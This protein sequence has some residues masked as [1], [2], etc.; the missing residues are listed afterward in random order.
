MRL[1]DI[2]NQKF[3]KLTAIER[4]V[5]NNTTY[6]KCLCDCG[7]WTT[8]RMS[9][10]TRT[11]RAGTKSCGCFSSPD[12]VGKKFGR[13]TVLNQTEKPNKKLTGSSFWWSCKCDCGKI[14]ATNTNSLNRGHTLSC[15]C[16]NREKV[17]QAN[18]HTNRDNSIK[19]S[20]A[21]CYQSYKTNNK[22]DSISFANFIKISQR[23]CFY[24]GVTG[25]NR[26]NK[27]LNREKYGFWA[28]KFSKENGYFIY[29][30]LDRVDN[31][32]DHTI[33][34]IVSCCKICN[35]F[36]LDRKLEEVN[37][38]F[39]KLILRPKF[40]TVSISTEIPNSEM[41][42]KIKNK[43]NN[44]KQKSKERKIQLSL[45]DSQ[46]IVLIKSNC[47]YCDRP[48][49]LDQGKFNGIDRVN[50]EIHYT[51]DNCVSCCKYC[52]AAKNNLPINEFI[53]WIEKIHNFKQTRL[54][55]IE[56]FLKAK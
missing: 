25:Y 12:L 20:A 49:D 45:T 54:K 55:N 47:N 37:L 22:N 8:V 26:F 35:I 21:D 27:F 13:L 6:W 56:D 48:A 30:G 2:S 5:K 31:S 15:G 33:D 10:L 14:I 18:S 4:V 43:I 1:K 36:K 40:A 17:S 41:G 9:D 24:C 3:G 7:A 53:S 46:I 50:N 29:N 52:N 23:P 51:L 42:A 28:S 39:D 32:K 19:A 34:N 16:Y 11:K 44:Y 38:H